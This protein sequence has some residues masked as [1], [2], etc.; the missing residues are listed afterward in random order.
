AGKS[1]VARLCVG[2]GDVLDDADHFAT[3]NQLV[4]SFLHRHQL[5]DAPVTAVEVTEM[6][7]LRHKEAADI[8][9][10]QGRRLTRSA[11]GDFYAGLRQRDGVGA[12]EI[13]R[14]RASHL[15]VPAKPG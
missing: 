2:V 6:P 14:N 9:P 10:I 8:Q 11:V 12:S 7:A 5:A 4:R 3:E 1:E 13:A 15:R